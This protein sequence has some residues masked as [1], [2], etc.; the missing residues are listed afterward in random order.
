[1]LTALLVVGLGQENVR[2]SVRSGRFCVGRPRS[3]KRNLGLQQ[4]SRSDTVRVRVCPVTPDAPHEELDVVVPADRHPS[5]SST[6]PMGRAGRL[7]PES[8]PAGGFKPQWW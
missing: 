5:K 1:M 3:R 6:G 8:S 7:P 4:H 2:L